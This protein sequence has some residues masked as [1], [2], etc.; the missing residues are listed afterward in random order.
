MQIEM[1]GLDRRQLH[2]L[3]GSAIVP[4]PIALISTVG[5][6]G[7]HNAAPF[8]LTFPICWKP[9]II[10]VSIG[11]RRGPEGQK[12]D[13]LA[14]IESSRDFVV[15][16]MDESMIKPTI[17]TSL[18]YPGSVDEIKEA[19]LTAVAAEKVKSPRIAEAQVSFECQVVQEFELGEGEN[20]KGI[21]LGEVV[22]THVKDE[23]WVDGGIDPVKL[24]SVGRLGFGFYCGTRDIIEIPWRKGSPELRPLPKS[25][26]K[27]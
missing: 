21:V 14:N 12:K 15:N 25:A 27:T 24:R 13:T 22:L 5:A 7:T 1:A 4:L 2:V 8:S 18:E 16:I 26:E 6:D 11:L 10:C 23:L 20:L 19:G 9:P 17:Q 3:L